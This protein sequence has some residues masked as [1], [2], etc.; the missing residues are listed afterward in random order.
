M[1]VKREKFRQL[2]E[3]RTNS[4][5]EVIARIGKLS[6]RHAYEFEDAE[7]RKILKALRDAV[8]EVEARFASPSRRT[9]SRFTL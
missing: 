9:E 1:N 8:G 6:N 7:V 5:I 2:A 4:A 3:R